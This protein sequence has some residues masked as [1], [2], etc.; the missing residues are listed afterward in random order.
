M[1]DLSSVNPMIREPNRL[2]KNKT[3]K[4]HVFSPLFEVGDAL[5]PIN[6][7]FERPL[8]RFW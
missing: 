3:S 4:K 7:G 6:R 8:K 2:V 5:N 1:F